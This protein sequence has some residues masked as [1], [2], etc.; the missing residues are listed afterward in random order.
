MH[1]LTISTQQL[2]VASLS[3]MLNVREATAADLNDSELLLEKQVLLPSAVVKL[4][5]PGIGDF[6]TEGLT[7]VNPTHSPP[8]SFSPVC[9]STTWR[10]MR[11]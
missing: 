4:A 3:Q 10:P 5:L 8:P 11:D 9:T 7:A 6:A 2:H 1:D